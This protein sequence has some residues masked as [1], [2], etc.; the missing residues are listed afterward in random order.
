MELALKQDVLRCE[1]WLEVITEQDKQMK[2]FRSCHTIEEL[3]VHQKSIHPGLS[4]HRIPLPDCCA[5]KEEVRP[6]T[7]KHGIDLTL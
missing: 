5:P 2:M 7:I 4:Y 3:F 6:L 1:K